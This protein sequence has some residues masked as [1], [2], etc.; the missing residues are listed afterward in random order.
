MSASGSP[1]ILKTGGD[2]QG[3]RRIS[4]LCPLA[5]Y[6][7]H[8]ALT[9][10]IQNLSVIRNNTRGRRRET[11]C[12]YIKEVPNKI[13]DRTHHTVHQSLLGIHSKKS[14]KHNL[15]P[16]VHEWMKILQGRNAGESNGNGTR[17]WSVR[18]SPGSTPNCSFLHLLP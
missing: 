16:S 13:T 2:R 7:A 3:R 8:A 17:T 15:R 4:G 14:H 1:Q 12:C 11:S 18:L 6:M 10:L 9:L 5:W